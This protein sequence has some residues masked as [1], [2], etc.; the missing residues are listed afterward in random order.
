MKVETYFLCDDPDCMKKHSM[1][2]KS[3][4]F[5]CLSFFGKEGNLKSELSMKVDNNEY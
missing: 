2:V 5:I 1:E 3:F 4:G